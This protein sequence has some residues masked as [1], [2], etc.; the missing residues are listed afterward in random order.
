MLCNILRCVLDRSIRDDVVCL[1]QVLVRVSCCEAAHV[2]A[3][4]ARVRQDEGR[5]L[6]G[7]HLFAELERPQIRQ[8]SAQE[9]YPR[10]STSQHSLPIKMFTYCEIVFT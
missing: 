10:E 5:S 3:V 8:R 4:R 2:A 7:A 6:Y 1:W 9:A